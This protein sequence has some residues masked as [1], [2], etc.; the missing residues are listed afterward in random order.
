VSTSDSDPDAFDCS[1]LVEWACGRLGVK[2][3]IP[4]GSWLQARHCAKRDTLRTPDEAVDIQGAL[5]FRFKGDPF[6][7]SRPSEAHVAISLGNGNTIEARGTKWGVGSF[8]VESRGWTH[9]GLVPGITYETPP[10]SPDPVDLSSLDPEARVLPWPGRFITQPPI[11]SGDDVSQWQEQ[12]NSRGFKL[13]VDGE[14]GEKSEKV[15]LAIQERNQIRIDGIVGP[16]T[17]MA[18]WAGPV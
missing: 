10:P 15:C 6:S 8:T 4:D 1:E 9:A 3:K 2:P 5:L 17:W 18:S 13:K 7:G 11:M 12:V 16:D 14:Y